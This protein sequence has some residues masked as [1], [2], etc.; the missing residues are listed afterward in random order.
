MF[1]K[2][3]V[4]EIRGIKTTETTIETETITTTTTKAEVS[5]RASLLTMIGLDQETIIMMVGGNGIEK[6]ITIM[7]V[8][9]LEMGTE[10]DEY[11]FLNVQ[12]YINCLVFHVL[13]N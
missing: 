3:K 2:I 9:T 4:T 11:C 13:T 7:E 5:I 1:R 12:L 6:T 10:G 8:A